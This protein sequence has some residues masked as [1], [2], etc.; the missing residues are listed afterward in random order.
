MHPRWP[1]KVTRGGKMS[2]DLGWKRHAVLFQLTLR[3]SNLDFED[4]HDYAYNCS[5]QPKSAMVNKIKFEWRM[6]TWSRLR[7]KKIK[8]RA[9]GGPPCQV[10]IVQFSLAFKIEC[11]LFIFKLKIEMCVSPIPSTRSEALHVNRCLF[12]FKPK[13]EVWSI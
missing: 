6:H 12:N 13:L 4:M 10:S 7:V 2:G 5:F 11:V 1:A 8:A 3:L 9:P